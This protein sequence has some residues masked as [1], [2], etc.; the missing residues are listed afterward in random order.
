MIF[1]SATRLRLRSFWFLLPF[2]RTN[3]STVRQLKKESRFIKGKLLIDRKLTFC[4]LTAW[5]SEQDMRDY[6]NSGA[7]LKAMP[8]L[9]RWCDEAHAAHWTQEGIELPD[10]NEAYR[11]I[12]A[13]EARVSKVHHPSKDHATKNFPPPRYPS[14]LE[15]NLLPT[16]QAQ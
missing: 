10:W 6:R 12:T 9:I 16:K 3:Q 14:K 11:H 2:L 8:K 4:T 5:A 1:I 7:H 15:S 13:P